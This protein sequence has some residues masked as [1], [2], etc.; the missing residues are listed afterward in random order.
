MSTFADKARDWWDTKNPRERALLLAL[1]VTVPITLAVW[2]GS[3]ISDGLTKIEKNNDT[4]RRALTTLADLRAR[5]PA[6]QPAD[7]VVATMPTELI[8]LESYLT[9]AAEKA[10]LKIPRF[11]PRPPVTR[12]GFTTHAMQIDLNDVT[13]DQ[14]R[15]FFEAVENDSR[16]VAVTALNASRK[17]GVKEKLNLKLEI[18]A[19][20]KEAPKG[21]EAPAAEGAGA[22]G[23]AAGAGGGSAAAS[24]GN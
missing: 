6:L 4:M 10:K 23:A 19:Y 21:A 5:G 3:Y 7:D 15:L 8:G 22:A 9:R 1:A 18:T 20:A 2:L 14:A 16:Y 24:G 12:N 11:N 13:L 17:L